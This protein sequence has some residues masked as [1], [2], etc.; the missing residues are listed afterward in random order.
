ALM[1]KTM[2]G[3]APRIEFQADDGV[4]HRIWSIQAPVS[5]VEAFTR[6]PALY[7]ADGHHRCKSASRV[8]EILRKENQTAPGEAEYDYFPAVLFPL[9]QMKILAYNR[10]IRSVSESQM[11][12]L[13]NSFPL[14]DQAPASPVSKG[15]VSLYFNGKWHGLTLPEGDNSDA[16][17]ELDVTRLQKHILSGIFGIENPRTDSNIDFVGGIRGTG[18]LE[19]LVDSGKAD[20][21][22]SMYPTAIEELVDV[23]DQGKLMPPKSTWFE[24]KLRSGLI[25][26]T[27]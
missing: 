14:T 20:L 11:K 7:V 6:I 9:D 21:A 18:E 23:S 13:T 27:F 8:A 19:K 16:V 4:W 3:S 25:I 22:I 17:E 15:D 12:A 5:V 24:P 10:I 26:H 1:D 2:A